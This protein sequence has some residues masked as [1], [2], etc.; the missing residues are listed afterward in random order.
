MYKIEKKIPIPQ[1]PSKL[2]FPFD[3]MKV[4]DSFLVPCEDNQRSN[5]QQKIM[6][7]A[8]Y[9]ILSNPDFKH[10]EFICKSEKGK[11]VRCWRTK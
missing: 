11:G 2:T 3:K 10:M 5:Y 4:G 8:R 7:K 6:T 9:K 1:R